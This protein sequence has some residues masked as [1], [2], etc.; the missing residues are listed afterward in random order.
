M[1]GR[2]GDDDPVPAAD[3]RPA[4]VAHLG[5]A[6]RFAHLAA[7]NAGRPW[8]VDEVQSE[9][10]VIL[11]ESARDHDSSRGALASFLW[12][13]VNCAARRLCRAH[14]RRLGKPLSVPVVAPESAAPP[15]VRRALRCLSREQRR[16]VSL[17]YGLDGAPRLSA[18][19]VAIRTHSTVP[20]VRRVEAEALSRLRS[21][22]EGYE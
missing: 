19:S 5:S 11:C 6:L 12:V 1:S 7:M 14:D 22:L 15:P 9:A 13:R 16:V 20:L 18:T 3:W 21:V 10:M 2:P 8:L 4:A 17:L